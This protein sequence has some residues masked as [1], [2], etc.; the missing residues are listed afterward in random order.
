MLDLAE[1]LRELRADGRTIRVSAIQPTDVEP[2]GQEVAMATLLQ[3]A[4]EGHPDDLNLVLVGNVHAMKAP[5]PRMPDLKP[6][7]AFLP[8]AKTITINTVGYFGEAWNCRGTPGGAA[9]VCQAWPLREGDPGPRRIDLTAG[10]AAFDGRF[11]VGRPFTASRP[12][13]AAA[14]TDR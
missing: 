4:S 12:E 2:G 11:S 1:G 6:M 14:P 5:N 9:P 7:A 3:A 10:D 13:S 8:A